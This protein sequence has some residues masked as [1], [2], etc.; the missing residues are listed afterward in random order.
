[1]SASALNRF[2]FDEK[3]SRFQVI[4][5]ISG[6]GGSSGTLQRKNEIGIP[7]EVI[8]GIS[9]LLEHGARHDVDRPLADGAELPVLS[10]QDPFVL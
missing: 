7:E 9:L 8:S 3:W 2:F 5:G 4:E 1:M 6:S 10:E